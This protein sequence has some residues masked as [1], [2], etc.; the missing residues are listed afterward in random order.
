MAYHEVI[1]QAMR[2]MVIIDI[3]TTIKT[4]TFVLFLTWKYTISAKPDFQALYNYF[5]LKKTSQPPIKLYNS[6]G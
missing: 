5:G 2:R 3:R 6:S 1:N 4:R